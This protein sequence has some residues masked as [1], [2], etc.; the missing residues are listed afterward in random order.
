M[1][2]KA[3]RRFGTQSKDQKCISFDVET[4]ETTW[5]APA[6]RMSWW[7]SFGCSVCNSEPLNR[8]GT[9]FHTPCIQGQNPVQE[10]PFPLPLY[11]NCWPQFILRG[12]FGKI[13]AWSGLFLKMSM[14]GLQHLSLGLFLAAIHWIVMSCF[15]VPSPETL[16]LDGSWFIDE[17]V[18]DP[19]QAL[20]SCSQGCWN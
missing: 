15:V 2:S 5:G 19:L 16:A 7:R 10:D 20:V 9:A 8:C 14:Q 4:T 12:K 18:P 13:G 17:R 6:T 11:S 3:L 1:I